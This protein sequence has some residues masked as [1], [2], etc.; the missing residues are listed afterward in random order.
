M[1]RVRRRSYQPPVLEK[2]K[3]I[4]VAITETPQRSA[5]SHAFKEIQEGELLLKAKSCKYTTLSNQPWKAVVLQ[6]LQNC[7]IFHFAGRCSE[8]IINPS[9]SAFLLYD[10]KTDPIFS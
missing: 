2:M 4:L 6:N 3:A 5:L 8:D 1:L 10:W 7:K 9:H